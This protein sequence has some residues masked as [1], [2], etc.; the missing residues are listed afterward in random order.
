MSLSHIGK[1]GFWIG[2]KMSKDH[3]KKI[4]LAGVG[5]KHTKG[6]KIKMSGMNKGV[7]NPNYGKHPSLDTRKKLSEA[8][9]GKH[10]GS[11]CNFWKGGITPENKKIR[12]SIQT[13]LWREAIFARDGWTCQKYQI[14]GGRLQIH[15]IKNFA[16]YPKLRFAID[17]GITLSREAHKEFHKRYGKKNNTKEQ[18]EEFLKN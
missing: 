3:R 12:N 10:T 4:G 5:R 7:K 8:G 18:L 17:N 2:K 14:E 6:W 9:M 15:H 13:C 1:P 11:K 16:Q